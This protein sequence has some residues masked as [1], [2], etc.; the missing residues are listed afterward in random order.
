M[1]KT[2]KQKR[3][4]NP[5]NI[6]RDLG[7]KNSE[8]ISFRVKPSEKLNISAYAAKSGMDISSYSKMIVLS[9]HEKLLELWDDPRE[10]VIDQYYQEPIKGILAKLQELYPTHNESELILKS[11]QIALDNENR[12]ISNKIKNYSNGK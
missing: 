6:R 8:T 12:I 4:P 7:E 5:N 2:T 1:A 10:Q 9:G 11:L 3:T